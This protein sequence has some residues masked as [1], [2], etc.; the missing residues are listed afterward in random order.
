MARAR[1]TDNKG[2]VLKT[3]ES[4]DKTGR[5]A[6]KWTQNGKRMTVY[7][8][9]LP[10]L[11][12]KEKA[13]Q[14]DI[15]S[16]I[17]VSKRNVTINELFDLHMET[18]NN[19][20]LTTR[21][22]YIAIWN[23]NVRNDFGKRRITDTNVLHVKKYY[24]D[25][26]KSG[27]S[28]ATVKEIHSMLSP[29]FQDAIEM[30]IIQNNPTTGCLTIL[31]NDQKEKQ[32]MKQTE[33]DAFL[34]FVKNS[35]VYNVYYPMLTFALSTGLRV[36]EL[37]GLRWADIDTEVH[38]RRQLV[39]KNFGEGCKFY[40]MD[41][42]TDSAYRTI[43]LTKTARKAL[44]QQKE[45]DL[46]TAKGCKRKEVCGVN[47]FCFT[48][49][50][51]KPFATNAFNTILKNIVSAYNEQETDQATKDHREPVLLPHI[52]AHTLRHT[53][54]TQL[55]ASGISAKVLQTIMGHSDIAVTMNVY[56]HLSESEYIR[57]SL[58][59]VEHK[60]KIG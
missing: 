32:A 52:S 15:D 16:G 42:K 59:A 10:E 25:L 11:R 29:V 51:G 31:K 30:C 44:I 8:L 1:R 22:N 33:L 9:T 14:Q 21:T 24:S 48:N 58:E 4:Q 5:Y 56:T 2:R 7:A 34:D 17:D 43:P 26:Q 49:K 27:L 53:A 36:G 45:I 38:V 12:E 60:I 40:F 13:I 28:K 37:T 39:Y 20:R 55:A 18:K 41:L 19:I 23:H 54:C 35:N 3:G 6:Y 47:D 57:E 46:M 50:S